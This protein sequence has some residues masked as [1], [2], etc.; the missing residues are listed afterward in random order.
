MMYEAVIGLEVHVELK[1]ESKIFCG[2]STRFGAQANSQVCPICLGMPG[3]LPRLNK[4]AAE[5]A[6]LAC[7]SLNCDIT[8]HGR[9]DRKNY[10]YADMPKGYQVSQVHSPIGLRGHVE[11]ETEEGTKKIGIRQIHL[12]E[13]AGKLVHEGETISVAQGSLVDLNRTGLPLIEIVS[14]PDIRT[15]EEAVA[16]LDSLKA[17]L[18]YIGVSDCKMEEGSLRCDGNISVRLK[19]STEFGP[20]AEIKNLNS[21]KS[22]QKS[23]EYEINRQIKTLQKGEK[24][25]QETRTWD[26]NKEITLSLRNKEFPDYRVFADPELGY[27]EIDDAWL[28]AVKARVPELPRAKRQRFIEKLGLPAYDAEILT[29]DKELAGF[30]EETLKYYL[31]AKKL[32]N[33]IMAEFMKLLNASQSTPSQ[34]LVKPED[35]A[36]LLKNIDKGEISHKIAKSVFDEMFFTGKKPEEIIKEKGY[37][38]I[39]D[40]GQLQAIVEKVVAGNPKS[41]EDYYN[42]KEKA[43]GFLVGQIM[44]ETKGQ[45]NPQLVNDLIKEHLAK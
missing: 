40:Q 21:F 9:L 42:G 8:R 10:Y 43:L 19:G 18:Q 5:H 2:C 11:I 25:V 24:V 4:Q 28:E 22:L 36:S 23:L 20:K 7:L 1:T 38:Q 34:S 32:S 37:A 27:I 15:P 16:Y 17:V 45:A 13:D 39:S 12:E 31:D 14:D 6:M 41:V 26:E 30:F 29:K 35:L 33:W 3:I 44:K